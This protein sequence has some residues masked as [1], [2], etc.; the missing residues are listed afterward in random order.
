MKFKELRDRINELWDNEMI[1]E[2]AE[3]YLEDY[4]EGLFFDPVMYIDIDKDGDLVLANNK[5]VEEE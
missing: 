1:S 4:F 3:V 2:E 5:R